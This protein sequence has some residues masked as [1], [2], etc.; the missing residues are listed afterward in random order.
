MNRALRAGY[1][2]APSTL[3][4]VARQTTAKDFRNK[5]S[6][7]L[8]EAPTLERVNESGAFKHGTIAEAKESYA[9]DSFGTILGFSRK[10]MINDDLG[11]LM[12]MAGKWGQA[13]VEFEAQFLVDLLVA[14]AGLGPNMHDANAL[15][16]A[17]HANL[18][19][20]GA[21]L[22]EVT[23]SAARLSMRTQKGLSGRPIN[24]APKFLIVPP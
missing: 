5:T 2:A 10:A 6:V 20:A 7:Q 24:V 16:H 14:N 11:A 4:A 17:S 23:L 9:I 12:D 22:S 21:V 19:G 13:S 3:K 1:A 8:G 18:A 15:F